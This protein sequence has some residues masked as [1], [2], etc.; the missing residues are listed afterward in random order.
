MNEAYD[1][2]FQN[3]DDTISLNNFDINKVKYHEFSQK[4]FDLNKNFE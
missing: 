3:M 2:I 4:K 1:S